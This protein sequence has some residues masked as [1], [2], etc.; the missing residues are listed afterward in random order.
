MSRK[1]LSTLGALAALAV[2]SSL[3]VAQT[4]PPT[5]HS[6]AQRFRTEEK[7]LQQ[8]STP[9]PSAS[10]PVDRTQAP[11]DAVPRARTRMERIDRFRDLESQM[12]RESSS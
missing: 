2:A 1:P 9:M 5:S 11:A 3:A 10:K 4:S 8:Q 12:Q 6:E 7:S